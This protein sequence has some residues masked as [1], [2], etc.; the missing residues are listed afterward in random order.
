MPRVIFTGWLG[1]V[2]NPSPSGA[3]TAKG[4]WSLLHRQGLYT[5][6][7]LPPSYGRS[8]QGDRKEVWSLTGSSLS[9][10]YFKR[11]SLSFSVV[12]VLFALFQL[13][14]RETPKTI[15][16]PL[17]LISS[18]ILYAATRITDVDP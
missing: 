11:E 8:D 17:H 10:L 4:R 15:A 5:S 13:I 1:T 14:S 16:L 3:I 6:K 7:F 18:C 12:R 9:F 2:A